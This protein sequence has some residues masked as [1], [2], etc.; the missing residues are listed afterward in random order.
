MRPSMNIKR[1]INRLFTL[2]FIVWLL[3]GVG[4]YYREVLTF[5]GSTYWT[6]EMVVQRQLAACN[7]NGSL[8]NNCLFAS[9][10]MVA[11]VITSDQAKT[12]VRTFVGLFLAVPACF[13]L[14]LWMLLFAVRW[15]AA[16]FKTE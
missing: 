3:I 11:S 9:H 10:P 15:V 8:E 13:Y 6:E 16:G 7:A 1:G 14:F 4:N 12:G 5:L 2:L